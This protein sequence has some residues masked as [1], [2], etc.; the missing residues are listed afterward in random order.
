M[1]YIISYGKP[2]KHKKLKS[3]IKARLAL[4]AVA[5]IAAARLYFPAAMQSIREV[6]LPGLTAQTYERLDTL[7]D[8]LEAGERLP[9]A[10]TAFCHD[11]L[12]EE[13]S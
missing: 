2:Q 9:E 11:V 3:T 10:L 8:A 12:A 6:L 5:V 1:A 7:A 4:G 13:I